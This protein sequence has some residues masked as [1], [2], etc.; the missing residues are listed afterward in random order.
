MTDGYAVEQT[1]PSSPEA[2]I[3]RLGDLALLL[4]A[5]PAILAAFPLVAA[6]VAAFVGRPLFFEQE[7]GGRNGVPFRLVKFRTMTDARDEAGRLLPDADRLKSFGI[8][9]RRTRL[10]ELP[11]FWHILTGEIGWVGPR[12]LPMHINAAHPLGLLR[13]RV[14]PGFTGLA[15]VSGNTLL[16]DEEKFAID[17]YYTQTRSVLGDLAILID[18]AVTITTG[19]RRNEALIRRALAMAPPAP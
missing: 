8:W 19:E 17:V 6:L 3:H 1:Q 2:L 16:S 5:A 9:L 13:L 14:K 4:L 12:P 11:S 7:R 15:Q 18:T 10:D